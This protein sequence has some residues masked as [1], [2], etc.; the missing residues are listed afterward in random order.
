M[1]CIITGVSTSFTVTQRLLG[2]TAGAVGT[3]HDGRVAT[4]V[5]GSPVVAAFGR[6][7]LCTGLGHQNSQRWESHAENMLS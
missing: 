5:L 7:R 2:D 1:D 3:S 6:H 4:A